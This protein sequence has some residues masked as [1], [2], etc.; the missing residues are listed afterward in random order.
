MTGNDDIFNI[1]FLE[2]TFMG[3]LL[4]VAGFRGEGVL[5]MAGGVLGATFLLIDDSYIEKLKK[6]NYWRKQKKL[7]RNSK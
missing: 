4:Y 5:F 6:F 1:L 2:I 7:W 3:L